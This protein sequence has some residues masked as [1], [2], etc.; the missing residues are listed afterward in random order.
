MEVYYEPN[1]E[2]KLNIGV[3]ATAKKAA[4]EKAASANKFEIA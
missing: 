3:G 4:L 2:Y 1:S